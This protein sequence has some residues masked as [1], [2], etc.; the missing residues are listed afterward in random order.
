MI[1]LL[2][3]AVPVSGI[4]SVIV[5]LGLD[6][7]GLILVILCGSETWS[8]RGDSDLSDGAVDCD[9][10]EEECWDRDSRSPGQVGAFLGAAT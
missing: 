2:A 10:A 6:R 8:P 1:S 3:L 5:S 4:N 7:Q 9:P